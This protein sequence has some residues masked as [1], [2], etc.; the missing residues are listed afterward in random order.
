M[1]EFEST[2]SQSNF[3]QLKAL[4]ELSEL[5][6]IIAC[7]HAKMDRSWTSLIHLAKMDEAARELLIEFATR[8]YA[9]FRAPK[10]GSLLV[11][12]RAIAKVWPELGDGRYSIDEQGIPYTL[13]GPRRG[14]SPHALLV[15]FSSVNSV[16][17]TQ[18]LNRH[19]TQNWP[20][21]EKSIV[22]HAAVLRISDLGGIVGSFY[23][24]TAFKEDNISAVQNLI[25][26]TCKRLDLKPEDVVL[27]GASKG[28]TGALLQALHGG[29]S[30]VS[31]DPI[32][33]N[34]RRETIE[35]DSY[36]INSRIF[37]QTRDA[38][39]RN[40]AHAFLERAEGSPDCVFNVI[41]SPRSAEYLSIA[42]LMGGDL[43]RFTN[44]IV[45]DNPR[46]NAHVDVAGKTAPIAMAMINLS[47]CKIPIGP[48]ET[49]LVE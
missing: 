46:I 23:L 19:F 35:A 20:G 6:E 5:P 38:V 40:A 43:E 32:V 17:F 22:D 25:V 18:S 41:T 37:P 36:F 39:F 42:N 21:L 2:T 33:T 9:V 30:C 12:E 26:N 49:R 34:V 29:Y 1:Y 8:G 45:S 11:H 16:P 48:G 28:G 4:D 44:L 7:K 10:E 24:P 47:L 13:S 3:K 27:Y 15:V 31:V 14:G